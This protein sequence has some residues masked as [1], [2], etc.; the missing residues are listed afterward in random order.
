MG[1]FVGYARVSTRDQ[2]VQLQLDALGPRPEEPP[3]V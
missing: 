2:D 1:K 3:K